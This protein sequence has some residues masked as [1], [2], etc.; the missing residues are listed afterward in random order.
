[1]THCTLRGPLFRISAAGLLL[2]LGAAR[3]ADAPADK[4]LL[5][6]RLPAD[7]VLTIEGG[8]T[9]QT[10][11]ERLFVSPPLAPG[12]RYS[13]TVKAEWKEDGKTRSEV[14][15]VVVAAGQQS[16]VVFGAG[17]GGPPPGSDGKRDP[18]AKPEGDRVLFLSRG[19]GQDKWRL[20]AKDDPLYAE[21]LIIALPGSGLVT[22]AGTVR[23]RLLRYLDSP[24]PTIEPAVVLHKNA[25]FDL[26][27]TLDRGL[28]EATN[29]KEKG[30]ARVLIRAQG[31]T[32]EATLAEPGSQLLVELYGAWPKGARFKKN[33]GPK[34]VPLA[35]MTFLVLKGQVDLKHGGDLVA[36]SAPP[37]PAQIEWDNVT[38]MD[39]SPKPLKELPAWVLPPT[40]DAGKE[41]ERLRDAVY[42]RFT[43]ALAS[44]PLDAVVDEFLESK[45]PLERRMAVVVLAATDDLARLGKALREAK[46]PDVWDDAVLALRHWMGRA[47]GQDLKLYNRLVESKNFTPEQAETVMQLL[48]TFSDVDEQRPALYEKL[49]DALDDDSFPV[50]ALAHWHLI[51][52]VPEGRKIA[53]DPHAPKEELQKTQKEWQALIPPGKL[54][55]APKEGDK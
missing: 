29:T 9:R 4:A 13:Y 42:R 6:V 22:N 11:G 8:A 43:E 33:P 45:N 52:L 55:P 44:K 37:G 40:D 30:A 23:L 50:R 15:E 26:D 24:L 5:L 18:I 17:A 3:A 32:W 28:V 31:E 53:Y 46:R 1:M 7:A 12:K 10:G 34:D 35:D 25:D 2:A 21:D 48:H 39:P 51:R 54:P 36:L 41:K 27:F 19:S 16:L 14:Q 20:S 49:I 47:P 38:G